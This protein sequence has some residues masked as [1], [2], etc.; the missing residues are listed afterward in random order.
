MY[1]GFVI[2]I[3]TLIFIIM[4]LWFGLIV[5]FLGYSIRQ[6]LLLGLLIILPGLFFLFAKNKNRVNKNKINYIPVS[7]PSAEQPLSS[8]E[9][10]GYDFDTL[11]N[12]FKEN[13]E[14]IFSDY[15]IA[16]HEKDGRWLLF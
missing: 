4:A 5:F 8:I 13:Y 9:K 2:F 3:V 16:I 14:E 10:D 6:G 15:G 7:D 12:M 11:K 1:K